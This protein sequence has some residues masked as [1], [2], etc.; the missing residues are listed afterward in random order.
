MKSLRGTLVLLFFAALV[1]G[2]IWFNERGPATREGSIELLRAPKNDIQ[3]VR[4]EN[5][6]KIVELKRANGSWQVAMPKGAPA[7]A[8][9]DAVNALLGN[10]ELVQSD[11][12]VEG[13]ADLKA[14]GLDK[15]RK[16]FVDKQ[17]LELGAPS[18]FDATRIYA[19]ANGKIA[20]VPA[21][22][23][24]AP[25]K[26][27][28][29][30]RDKRV[31][32]LDAG[33]LKEISIHTPKVGAKFVKTDDVWKMSRPFPSRADQ[34]ALTNLISTF[35][36]ATTTR[37]LDAKAANLGLDTPI[38]SL[39]IGD[40]SL[41]VGKKLADGYAARSNRS[42]DA[43]LLSNGT[44][45]S[46]NLPLDDWRDKH[47]ASFKVADATRFTFG[48]R[49]KT[50]TLKKMGERWQIEGKAPDDAH[51]S[52]A[53]DVLFWANETEVAEFVDEASGPEKFGLQ[54]P[55]ISLQIE[56][57]EN[58]AV[59]VGRANGN[60]YVLSDDNS[61]AMLAPDAL[62]PLQEALDLF[63]PSAPKT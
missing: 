4:L 45:E 31:L 40:A 50:V 1:G 10:L 32:R 29:D 27:F 60:I 61:L 9:E 25:A 12:P 19:R 38:A 34:T 28:V 2:Y 47:I 59:K 44:F 22:L 41:L 16:I 55:E 35:E 51:N 36:S 24:E 37:W 11:A 21:V 42:N 18:P 6:G 56:A 23:A 54:T 8:D 5:A 39:Q 14:F 7:R 43:F 49:G 15:P 52:R 46:F 30:W 33:S 58:T 26:S 53:L 62:E 20:L 48:A 13:Q 63:F 17:L 57:R 3:T